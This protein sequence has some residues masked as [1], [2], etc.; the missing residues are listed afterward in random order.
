LAL[1]IRND[2]VEELAAKL[3]KLTGESK[4]AAVARALRERLERVQRDRRGRRLA[5][6]LDAIAQRCARL[7]VLDARSADEIIGYDE[8]GLVR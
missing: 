6:E 1:N 2:D 5:D 3:A 7:P 4:T 8:H